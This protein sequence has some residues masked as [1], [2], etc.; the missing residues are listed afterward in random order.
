MIFSQR[1]V[2]HIVC[3]SSKYPSNCCRGC[4]ADMKLEEK[5]KGQYQAFD[6]WIEEWLASV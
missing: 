3:I 6:F 5:A 1:Y 4:Q 2:I